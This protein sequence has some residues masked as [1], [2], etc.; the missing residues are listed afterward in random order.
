MYQ[1][2]HRTSRACENLSNCEF[3]VEKVAREGFEP[4]HAEDFHE[5]HTEGRG[6]EPLIVHVFQGMALTCAPTAMDF[7]FCASCAL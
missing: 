7:H 3:H 6:F 4:S 1:C 5:L 2:Q